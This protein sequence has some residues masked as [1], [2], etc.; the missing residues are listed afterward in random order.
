MKLKELIKR[1]EQFQIKY[2]NINVAYM[3]N[4][5]NN[6]AIGDNINVEDLILIQDCDTKEYYIEIQ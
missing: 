4:L 1:L 6:G 5:K 2:G 3:D